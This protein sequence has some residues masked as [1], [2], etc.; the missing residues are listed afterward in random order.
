MARSAKAHS[1]NDSRR[2]T[3]VTLL[4]DAP[5][6]EG[7]EQH[8]VDDQIR[9]RAY[10][11]YLERGAAPNDD[12]GDWLRAEREYRGRSRDDRG[13]NEDDHDWAR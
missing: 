9:M 12:L 3:G 10:E 6:T 11:L 5:P 7:A 2:D 13:G 8:S 4:A 1:M